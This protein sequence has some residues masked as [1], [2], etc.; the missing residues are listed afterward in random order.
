MFGTTDTTVNVPLRAIS[1][2]ESCSRSVWKI[3]PSGGCLNCRLN[4]CVGRGRSIPTLSSAAS[5][6]VCTR[7]NIRRVS[8]HSE[9]QSAEESR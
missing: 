3:G 2:A 4:I 7:Q 6:A 9:A 5:E 8:T 1:G